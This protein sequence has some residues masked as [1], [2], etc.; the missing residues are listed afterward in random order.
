MRTSVEP[1]EGNKV[2]LHVAI[3]ADEF[4]RAVDAAFRSLAREVKIPG[5][6]PG[7]VPRRILERRLGPEVGRERALRD[8]LPG[9]YRD[10]LAAERLDA[11]APPE[12]DLTAGAEAGDVEFDAVVEVRPTFTLEGWEGL[13]V[14][15]PYEPPGDEAV[16]TQLTRLRE[17]FATLEDSAAP[18]VDG[19]VA[20]IDLA[21]YVH[22]T[23]VD[24]LC[25][26]DFAYEV[27]SGL[28]SPKLDAELRGKRPGDILKLTDTLPDDARRFGEHAGREVGMRVLVKETQRKRLP[29]LTDDWV[30]EVSE[31]STVA[32]LREATAARL[33]LIARV[34][35]QLAARDKILDALAERVPVAAP[36]PLVREEMERR[37]HDLLHRLEAQGATLEQY[38][39]A[40]GA[41]RDA[42]V[43]QLRAGAE[44]AVLAD[45]A[46]GAIVAQEGIEVSDEELAAEIAR[47]AER[48][49]RSPEAV[50]ADLERRDLLEAVRSDVARAKALQLA[51]ERAVVV[52]RGGAELDL[53][54]PPG[55]P[56]TDAAG[57]DTAAVADTPA[58]PG[59]GAG[60]PPGT[61]SAAAGAGKEA[62][63]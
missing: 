51:V 31:F 30:A 14:E 53:T 8:A 35:A 20:V 46:L 21:G 5:F 61:E 13:R 39:Q 29:D 34:Q 25:A 6:R 47:I 33:D 41:D 57:A 18:L 24:A 63:G 10:A 23:P 15:V 4:E 12:I 59:P 27:G 62:D 7:K 28:V 17:R 58:A 32:E 11:I 44:R 38:L 2:R 37:L 9:Y 50:R 16:D 48:S 22:D 43:A 26:D 42:F 56:A 40:V 60:G 36:E 1:L 54:L 52:D 45:L 3:P 55:A 49:G 19:D